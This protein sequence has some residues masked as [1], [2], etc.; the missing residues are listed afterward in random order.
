MTEQLTRRQLRAARQ[1]EV[2][3]PEVPAAPSVAG[4]DASTVTSVPVETESTREFQLSAPFGGP[5]A[6]VDATKVQGAGFDPAEPTLTPDELLR[7]FRERIRSNY[8]EGSIPVPQAKLPASAASPQP[9]NY[10]FDIDS[11][12]ERLRAAAEAARIQN[13]VATASETLLPTQQHESEPVREISEYDIAA[14]Q[15]ATSLHVE[16]LRES[17]A[18]YQ[19]TAAIESEADFASD[20]VTSEQQAEA[21]RVSR[22]ELR[23]LAES[24]SVAAPFSPEAQI[25]AAPESPLVIDHSDSSSIEVETPSVNTSADVLSVDALR[26]EAVADS[27][28]EA[29]AEPV[30]FQGK[31]LLAEP[32]TQSIVLD[33]IPDA[34]T[35]P[36]NL[37]TDGLATGSISIIPEQSVSDV[38]GAIAGIKTDESTLKDTVTGA[39][40]VIEP[41]SALAVIAERRHH[42]VLPMTSLRRGWWQPYAVAVGIFAMIG[43]AAYAVF[44]ILEVLNS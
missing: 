43:A 16:A 18:G 20:V 8:Q 10:S 22:R 6:R 13:Q 35:M 37:S 3:A 36:I 14:R 4:D 2:V 30:D 1:A 27:V 26:T 17:F 12:R 41:V 29:A 32:S 38:T 5:A 33:V 19:G 23:R 24:E 9:E 28:A 40:S 44:L 42:A 31:N 39:V 21:D 25:E 7:K 34:V 11:I 15:S